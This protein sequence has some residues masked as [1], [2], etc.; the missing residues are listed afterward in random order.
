MR[1]FVVQTCLQKEN[2]WMHACGWQFDVL[3]P[4]VI[5]WFAWSVRWLRFEFESPILGQELCWFFAV[6]ISNEIPAHPGPLVGA[7]VGPSFFIVAS[8]GTWVSSDWSASLRTLLPNVSL[9]AEGIC[10]HQGH[11]DVSS[12]ACSCYSSCFIQDAFLCAELVLKC[13]QPNREAK[14]PLCCKCLV[15]VVVVVVAAAVQLLQL[16]HSCDWW[17]L[18][19]DAIHWVDG[20]G[21][22]VRNVHKT[23]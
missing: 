8:S 7:G 20:R 17:H 11:W 9:F 10:Q 15:C 21:E 3:K 4:Q 5:I 22:H 14:C 19:C 1:V 2:K 12:P 23:L 16:K 13:T 6:A 18:G